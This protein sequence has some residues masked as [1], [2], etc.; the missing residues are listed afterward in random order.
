ML[1]YVMEEGNLPQGMLVP[2]DEYKALIETIEQR[3]AQ[4]EMAEQAPKVTQAVK[5]LQGTSEEG[6]PIKLLTGTA[7]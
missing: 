7:A 5:N 6:S 2:E 1:E 3:M 4:A